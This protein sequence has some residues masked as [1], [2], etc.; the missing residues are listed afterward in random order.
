[1]TT[2]DFAARIPIEQADPMTPRPTRPMG[3]LGFTGI[4]PF[5]YYAQEESWDYFHVPLEELERMVQQD[6]QAQS[7]YRILTMPI[8]A[9]ETHLTAADGGQAEYDFIC[10]QLFQSPQNGGMT[11]P[12]NRVMAALSRAVLTGAEVLEKCYKTATID[13]KDRIL[14][15]RIAPRPRRTLRFRVDERGYFNG[16]VQMVPYRG[17]IWIE[18]PKC[19]HFVINGEMNPVFGQSMLLPAYYHYQ[20]KHKLYYIGHLGFAVAALALKKLTIPVGADQNDRRT[21]EQAAANMGMNTTI[22]IPEGYGLELDYGAKVPSEMI[23]FVNHHDDQ[24]AKAVLAQILNLGTSGNTGSYALSEAHL[25]LVFI[26]IESIM[27]DMTYLFNT[28]VIPELIDW[29]FGTSKYPVLEIAPS[30]TDRRETIKDIFRHIS[31]ARQV[32]TS[33]EFWVELEKAMAQQLGFSD[34]I[35][36]DAQGD[37]MVKQ[38]RTRQNAQ[39]G[40]TKKPPTSVPGQGPQDPSTAPGRGA[41]PPRQASAPKGK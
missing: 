29:N 13:G 1:M 24:M 16:V 3:E 31:A 39:T 9:S 23:P 4:N 15:D 26:V 17:I 36:Y 37:T 2:A 14:L 19:L 30:Y 10:R 6:G 35:N 5:G 32:N 28:E 18:K 8:R 21:F 34:N 22:S 41:P 27:D 12:W 25:D 38:A 7:L 11:I 40:V 33:A 20:K